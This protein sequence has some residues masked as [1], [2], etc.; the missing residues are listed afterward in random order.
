VFDVEWG[1]VEGVEFG[2]KPTE[3]MVDDS[4][5][6]QCDEVYD[7]MSTE[8]N[9]AVRTFAMANGLRGLGKEAESQ[10]CARKT[11][12]KNKKT[13]VEKKSDMKLRTQKSP[14][15]ADAVAILVELCRRKGAI[16]ASGDVKVSDVPQPSYRNQQDEYAEDNYL[17]F[18]ALN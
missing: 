8:L 16:P 9:L 18:Y 12:Y 2:G 10:F 4:D 15:E 3:R 14:D 7:R 6:K 11:I 1:V 13:V 17:T 5:Q